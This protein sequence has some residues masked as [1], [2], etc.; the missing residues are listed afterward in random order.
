MSLFARIHF[1]VILV[2]SEYRSRHDYGHPFS[3]AIATASFDFGAL[4]NTP[5]AA[6]LLTK[7]L[8]PMKQKIDATSNIAK[9]R[10]YL[11]VGQMVISLKCRSHWRAPVLSWNGYMHHDLLLRFSKASDAD[12]LW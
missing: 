1:V 8:H 2:V 6:H 7:A 4:F 5:F 3:G 12:T 9:Y 10:L 11:T